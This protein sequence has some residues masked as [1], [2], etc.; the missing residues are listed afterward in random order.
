VAGVLGDPFSELDV[1]TS[2]NVEDSGEE[3]NRD[4]LL[5]CSGIDCGS[6]GIGLCGWQVELSERQVC[7]SDFGWDILTEYSKTDADG[8]V[9]VVQ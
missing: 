2:D 1:Y 5:R 4:E 6:S 3:P 9:S 8:F 7:C